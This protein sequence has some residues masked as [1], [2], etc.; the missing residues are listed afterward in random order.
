M[1]NQIPVFNRQKFLLIFIKLAGSHLSKLDLQKLLFLY[2]RNFDALYY[3]FIPYHYGCYSFQVNA[4]LETLQHTGWLKIEENEISLLNE[5]VKALE[6]NYKEVIN[7]K[8]F[9][10]KHSELKGKALIKHVYND[11]PYYAIN[12]KIA[13]FRLL[14]NNSLKKID[15]VRDELHQYIEPMLFTIGYEGISLES[16]INKLIGKNIKILCDVR[17]NPLSRKFGFSKSSLSI[18]LPKIG[19]KYIHIPE[20]GIQSAERKNLNSHIDYK[21]LFLEY[22]NSLQNKLQYVNQICELISKY[23]RIALTCFEKEPTMCHRYY[24]SAF[25]E[26][27]YEVKAK[28][29]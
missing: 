5:D 17:N 21:K 10:S 27:N 16:Y 18:I 19:I 9:M 20:L 11:Y 14:E 4:D 29:I 3:D 26:A 1:S 25:I 8:G 6:C 7:I 23:K 15:K 28:N 2:H 24:L 22:E 13:D 12:S